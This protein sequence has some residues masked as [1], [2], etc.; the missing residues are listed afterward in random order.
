MTKLKTQEWLFTID[1]TLEDIHNN[2]QCLSNYCTFSTP[3]GP[4]FFK[5]EEKFYKNLDVV[6]SDITV[7]VGAL[8]TYSHRGMCQHDL[9][10]TDVRLICD[11]DPQDSLM[12]P[13][14]IFACKNKRRVCEVCERL[15]AKF[16]VMRDNAL[17]VPYI[18]LCEDCLGNNSQQNEI[19]PYVHD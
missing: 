19:Y 13:F 18:Y 15:H 8:C 17:G 11:M 6:L 14:Q 4:I 16:I 2:I 10:V 3:P 1:K 5:F 7:S 12:Y 9:I